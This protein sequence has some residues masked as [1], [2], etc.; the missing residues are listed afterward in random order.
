M[1]EGP[2]FLPRYESCRRETG[3]GMAHEVARR[4]MGRDLEAPDFWA[5]AIRTLE[6]PIG[7]LERVVG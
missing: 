6:G 3:S 2:A 4:T 5:D 7:E 1:E